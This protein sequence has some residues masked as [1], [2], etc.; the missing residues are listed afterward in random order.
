MKKILIFGLKE[1]IGGVEK[2][3]NSY[4]ENFPRKKIVCD[5]IIF[6]SEFS[7]QK[8]ITEKGGKVFYLPNRI[9]RRMEYKAKIEAIF[10]QN[11]YDAVWCNF[12]GLTNIDVLKLGKKYGVPLR[13]A[14]SHAAALTWTGRM[15]KYLVPLFHN[16]NKAVIHK[17]ATDFWA[18]SKP[19]GDFM[20]PKKIQHKIKVVNNAV[21]TLVFC[22]DQDKKITTRKELGLENSFVVCHI[23]R[24]CKEK[25]QSFMLEVFKELLKKKNNAKLLFVGDGELKEQIIQ[26]AKS[27]EIMDNVIFVGFKPQVADY[28][29]ASDVFL[30]PS[31]CEGLGLSLIEA[32]ACGVPCVASN[33][34]PREADITGCVKFVRLDEPLNVWVDA[35]LEISRKVI[36]DASSAVKKA[37]YDIKTEAEKMCSFFVDKVSK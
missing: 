27:L 13:I 1:P 16:K 29:K 6:G 7:L 36:I 9:K 33:A 2:V 19:A 18:C 3:V 32:Q 26:K 8:E 10:A 22:V 31:I 21:D 24:M 30:F 28:Y 23:A 11:K 20:F 5:F 37:N 35:I 34:V 12:S 15:M 17:Y 4:V 25:N 14:H